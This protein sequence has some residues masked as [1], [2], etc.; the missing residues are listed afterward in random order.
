[1]T[2]TAIEHAWNMALERFMYSETED[3]D[4]PIVVCDYD[5]DFIEFAE[6]CDPPLSFT[7]VDDKVIMTQ[8]TTKLHQYVQVELS[9]TIHDAA[10]KADLSPRI[11]QCGFIL[12]CNVYSCGSVHRK[13]FDGGVSLRCHRTDDIFYMDRN[14]E[15]V[16]EMAFTHESPRL[17]FIE[18]CHFLT[19]YVPD[20]TYAIGIH[21]RPSRREFQLTFFILQRKELFDPEKA[22]WIRTLYDKRGKDPK[23]CQLVGEDIA[24]PL[25]KKFVSS[26][27]GVRLVHY[28]VITLGDIHQGARIRFRLSGL[29]LGP[30]R[31]MELSNTVLRNLHRLWVDWRNRRFGQP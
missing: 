20:V 27:F 13:Y 12:C 2:I 10:A 15:V 22:E 21:I 28:Q 5:G 1:M 26:T 30:R 25:N 16:F 3:L 24:F 4:E 29:G 19:G 31:V 23:L 9:E 8:N 11:S 14:P 7:V 6:E 18:C 17:L